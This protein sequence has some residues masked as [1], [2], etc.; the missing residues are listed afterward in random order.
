MT[1]RT[2]KLK[3]DTAERLK[4]TDIKD[5]IIY[6]LQKTVGALRNENEKLKSYINT[7]KY[8]DENID[9]AYE[10]GFEQGQAL[11]EHR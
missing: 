5:E 10:R 3:S 7:H 6:E 11:S 9:N 8:T 1:P 2:I 4:M